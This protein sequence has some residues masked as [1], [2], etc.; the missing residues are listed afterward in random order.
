MDA[1]LHKVQNV[2]R[3]RCRDCPAMKKKTGRSSPPL[4]RWIPG[5]DAQMSEKIGVD[6][7]V[8]TDGGPHQ[9]W[10]ALVSRLHR[11]S[12]SPAAAWALWLRPRRGDGSQM[13]LPDS[14]TVL[15]IAM[16]VLVN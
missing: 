14:T 3:S 8:V 10:V 16:G 13:G 7:T 2:D 12:W 11:A 15:V 5:H 1:L 6:A 4:R 9:M